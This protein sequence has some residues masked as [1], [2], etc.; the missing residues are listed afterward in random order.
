M[1]FRIEV[2]NGDAAVPYANALAKLRLKTY[3][4]YPYLYVGKLEDELLY[5]Q[6]YFNDSRGQII[7]GFEGKT[8]AG[9]ASGLPLN[10]TVSFLKDWHKTLKQHEIDVENYFY[11]GELIIKPQFQKQGLGEQLV[12][13]MCQEARSL[14][15]HK[16]MLV[17]SIRDTNH[18]L[19]PQDYFDTDLIWSKF[20][21]VKSDIVFTCNWLTQQSDGY[22]QRDE[23]KLGCW[24]KNL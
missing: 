21:F 4:N 22:V 17:T 18:P 16:M 23:N 10:A 15:F 14:G 8:I 19:R 12:K 2:F 1:T 9:I 24:M 7:V 3:C 6:H 11:L 20:G 5:I 13:Q